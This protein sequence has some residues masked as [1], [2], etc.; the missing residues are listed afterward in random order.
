MAS[1]LNQTVEEEFRERATTAKFTRKPNILLSLSARA[2]LG[3]Q[4]STLGVLGLLRS[5]DDENFERKYTVLELQ[6]KYPGYRWDEPATENQA[7]KN[8]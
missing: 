1:L 7:E 3:V 8:N 2:A 5:K 4:D 6:E